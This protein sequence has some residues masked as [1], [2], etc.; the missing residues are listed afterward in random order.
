MGKA[1][2][3]RSKLP[4][5]G[6]TIIVVAMDKKDAYYKDKNDIIGYKFKV[7]DPLG[8]RPLS[9]AS[10]RNLTMYLLYNYPG[11]RCKVITK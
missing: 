3:L 8:V 4:S 11:F 10:N 7:I 6:S 5:V 2:Y 9:A 1:K